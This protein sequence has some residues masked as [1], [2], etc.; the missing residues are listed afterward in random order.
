[1]PTINFGKNIHLRAGVYAMLSDLRVYD[2]MRYMADFSLIYN[3]RIGSVSLAFT[4]Y[5]FD[6]W[7]NSYLSFN[8]GMPLFGDRSLFY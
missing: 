8:F 6:S 1:M 5:N 4:K 7:N 3:T 2:Y